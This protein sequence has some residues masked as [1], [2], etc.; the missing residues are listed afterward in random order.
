[1]YYVN[2][3]GTQ[4]GKYLIVKENN[5]NLLEINTKNDNGP[6]NLTTWIVVM[7]RPCP[8]IMD[9]LKGE[10]SWIKKHGGMGGNT[11]PNEFASI[12]KIL[13][14]NEDA[15]INYE[16]FVEDTLFSSDN[17]QVQYNT[18]YKQRTANI[19]LPH[20]RL[21]LFWVIGFTISLSEDILIF[22]DGTVDGS[23]YYY[24][25]IK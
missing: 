8:S 19:D 11:T 7:Q 21:H 9:M 22:W 10:W 20:V 5:G 14:Q 1:V 12:V 16:V 18:V 6:N 17:F 25:K 3:T 24:Q 23:Y 2:F 15:S 4:N 13:S